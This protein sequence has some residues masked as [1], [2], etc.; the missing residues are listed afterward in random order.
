[1][2]LRRACA[3]SRAHKLA[4]HGVRTASSSAGPTGVMM[5][6]MGG[7]STL[8]EV[9]PFLSNLFA[10]GE[11][12]TLGPLQ[13]TLG[14]FIAKRRTPKIQEQYAEI[15]G[16]SPIGKWTEI[17]GQGMVELL[18]KISPETAP[19]KAYTGFRYANPLTEEAL[20]KMKADGVKRV[21]AF[22]QYP[23]FS[24]TTA[25]SSYN[26]LWR[27]LRRLDM[28]DDFT[29]SVL[30]RWPQHPG[31]IQAVAENVREGLKQF[32]AEVR[33][34]VAILFS[35]HSIPMKVVNR[36]DQYTQEVAS[37]VQAVMT[38]LGFSNRYILGWQSKVGFL[39]WMGPSTSNVIEGYGKQGHRY[40]MAVPIAF[41]SDHVETLFEIDIE[42]AEEA[43]K[44][45]IEM[46]KRAPS[47][48]GSK[49][50]QAA[51]ADIVATHLKS[52]EASTPQ[53]AM[54]CPGCVNSSCRIIV[55]PV[56]PYVRHRDKAKGNL[57]PAC[58]KTLPQ[59]GDPLP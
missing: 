9:G 41:T 28:G 10:D 23:Q 48:N 11:I 51:L 30:D 14:P 1:M 13:N 49:T 24:C 4:I 20:L 57:T 18:D 34:E 7:P 2:L 29:W 42:Y 12:I 37:T 40:V 56:A 35:A 54:N 25:G 16:G 47:L 27:E 43:E 8:D 21:V 32:P 3:H 31:F 46:F 26:H 59:I 52:G 50:F 17:Q 39:P 33:D 44:A 15:G 55:N 45:G 5:L 38:E 53:Y 58:T 36:G 19:H 22:S 6:N